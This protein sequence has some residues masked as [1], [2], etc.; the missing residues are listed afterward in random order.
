MIIDMNKLKLINDVHG[1]RIG[2]E[3]L[4]ALASYLNTLTAE[5]ALDQARTYRPDVVM[6]AHHDASAGAFGV[7]SSPL[8]RHSKTKIRAL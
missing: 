4:R 2:D 6:P 7:P 8:A 5:L 3:A 1:H